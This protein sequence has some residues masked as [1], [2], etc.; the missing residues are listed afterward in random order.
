[1]K[2]SLLK[3]EVKQGM[4]PDERV[5]LFSDH[6]GKKFSI[7]VQDSAVTN[8]A[9]GLG[10]VEVRVIDEKGDVALVMLPGEVLGASRTLTVRNTDLQINSRN[11]HH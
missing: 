7:I 10:L 3:G 2:R 11:G 8:I 6:Q 1:M 4:F 9:G 5:V